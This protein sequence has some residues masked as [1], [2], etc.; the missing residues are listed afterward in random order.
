VAYGAA[1]GTAN[2]AAIVSGGTL[3]L[4]TTGAVPA[5]GHILVAVG[6]FNSTTTGL[7][8]ISGG[9]LTWATARD[10]GASNRRVMIFIAPCPAGL[11]ASTAITITFTTG[12]SDAIAAAHYYTGWD[13]VGTVVTSN[14]VVAAT[15]GWSSGNM[16][17]AGD[18][19]GVSFVDNGTTT[20]STPTAPGVERTDLNIAGQAETLTVVDQLNVSGTNAVAGTWNVA[21]SHAAAGAVFKLAA[22]G[23][24]VVRTLSSTGAGR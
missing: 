14:S 15:A 16:T 10:S 20:S 2:G 1:I 8:S 17:G 6:R 24:P 9:G 5:G 23:A 22:A 7:P 4:T 3:V 21:G 11:A 13:T 12:T 19:V 18:A